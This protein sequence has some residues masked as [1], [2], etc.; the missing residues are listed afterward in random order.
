MEDIDNIL[1][2]KIDQLT[3]QL[4][5][6]IVNLSSSGFIREG[7][8]KQTIVSLVWDIY[9]VMPDQREA[10]IEALDDWEHTLKEAIAKDGD[11][12]TPK[13]EN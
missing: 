4:A 9:R 13:T 7:I 3:A 6:G 5:D 11:S 12:A 10:L 2:A 8:V 1:D